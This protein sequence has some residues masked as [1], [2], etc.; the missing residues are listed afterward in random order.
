M[1]SGEIVAPSEC[2]AEIRHRTSPAKN[3][4]PPA[5]RFIPTAVEAPPTT[6]DACPV[7]TAAGTGSGGA[8]EVVVVVDGVDT[9]E[10]V[11]RIG[12]ATVVVVTDAV[13]GKVGVD[14]PVE[15]VPRV[16]DVRGG[17]VSGAEPIGAIGD[18]VVL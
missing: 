8:I 16:L 4:I 11:A 13:G 3:T 18:V 7:A 5:S 1:I 10:V 12:F 17:S 14:T 9:G 15:R 2:R 6:A